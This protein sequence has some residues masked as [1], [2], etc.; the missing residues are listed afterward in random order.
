[1]IKIKELDGFK[2]IGNPPLWVDLP[3]GMNFRKNLTYMRLRFS[4]WDKDKSMMYFLE[5]HIEAISELTDAIDA[6]YKEGTYNLSKDIHIVIRQDDDFE[7][8]RGTQFYLITDRKPKNIDNYISL[9]KE[10]YS[11]VEKNPNNPLF[12][13][14]KFM[15]KFDF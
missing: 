13:H 14:P 9:N 7:K 1:M 10:L 3:R 4:N 15:E 11:L 8:H 6:G 12:N 2:Y 5:N